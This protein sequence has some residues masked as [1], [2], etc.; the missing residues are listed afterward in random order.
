MMSAL[1]SPKVL[2]P[3][4]QSPP[5]MGHN[6]GYVTLG[7]ASGEAGKGWDRLNVRYPKP[8]FHTPGSN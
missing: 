3:D 6:D 1:T 8:M 4:K 7:L 5:T 2:I